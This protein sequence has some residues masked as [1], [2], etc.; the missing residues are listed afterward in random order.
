[1]KTVLIGDLHGRDAWKHIITYE[2]PDRVV[3]VGDYFDSF[4]IPYDKQVN[5]FLDLVE[6]KKSGNAEVIMLLGNHDYHYLPY[7]NDTAT[8]GYQ[9]KYGF[10]LKQVLGSNETHLQ[11]AYQFDD[12]L[13]TH[14][15]VSVEFMDM[16]VKSWRHDTVAEDLNELFKYKPNVFAFNGYDPYGDDTY[17]TPIWIRTKSLMKANKLSDLKRNVVQIFG[18]TQV[19]RKIDEHGHSTGG[20]YY[21]IDALGSSGEYMIV[22]GDSFISFNSYKNYIK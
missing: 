7:I 5:N 6:F 3:F 20:R 15:G 18:H 9:T 11:M 8:S 14:A 13:V 1:M 21:N 4:D 19:Y 22:D 17:Q 12:F 16:H 2:K 10:F